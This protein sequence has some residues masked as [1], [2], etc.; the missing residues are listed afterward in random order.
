MATFSQQ[1]LSQLGSPG[2]LQGA[3]DL[4]GAIGG[5]PGQMRDKRILGEEADELKNSG[6]APG[7]AGYLSIQAMQ[8]ARRG[9]KKRAIDLAALAQQEKN[10]A[11][12]LKLAQE[13]AG[14]KLIT[15]QQGVTEFGQQQRDRPTKLEREKL[16]HQQGVTEFGQ[17][18]TDRTTKLAG[19]EAIAEG[20]KNDLAQAARTKQD[21][22]GNPLSQSELQRVNRMLLQ[23]VQA[24]MGAADLVEQ[25][26]NLIGAKDKELYVI[27]DVAGNQR[28][29]DIGPQGYP[30]LKLGETI[31]KIPSTVYEGV[32]GVTGEEDPYD[33]TP[34]KFEGDLKNTN[35][36]STAVGL[37]SRARGAVEGNT[38]T[39]F[40]VDADEEIQAYQLLTS[41]VK[42]VEAAFANSNKFPV[43]ELRQIQK[44]GLSDLGQSWFASESGVRNKLK[45][46]VDMFETMRT[47]EINLK[48][49]PNT[50]PGAKRNSQDK[51][52]VLSSQISKIKGILQSG[53]QEAG[54]QQ[55]GIP[56]N[57]NNL[58]NLYSTQNNTPGGG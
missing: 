32:V 38:L 48:N 40:L 4:G 42:G 24:G 45:S 26:N 44:L 15:H 18:Q 6:F 41:V 54:Q 16:A 47:R 2:M 50:E 10:T 12:T 52:K 19:T 56:A 8:A 7:T 5:V 37:V 27:T 34:E 20:V 51:A 35:V 22:D 39:D 1:F 57:V 49:D 55:D 36:I 28:V 31:S 9:D 17:Q 23:A 25:K 43:A 3:K 21:L 29:V 53:Q 58:I 11:A 46:T 14:R 30:A 33:I 13:E